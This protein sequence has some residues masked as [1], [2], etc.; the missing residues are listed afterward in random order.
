LTQQE[1]G[2]LVQGSAGIDL[3]LEAA[4][5]IHNRTDGNPF[6]VGEVTRH[7]TLENITEDPGWASIIPEGVRDAIGRRLNRLSDHCNQML[8]T[9]SV[10]GQEFEFRLLNSLMSDIT[11]D[12]LLAAMDEAVEV[13]LIEEL[14]NSVGLYQFTHPLIQETLFEELSTTRRVRLHARIAEGLET[15]YGNDADV[16]AEE[17]AYHFAEAQTLT[18]PEKLVRYSLMA[19]QQ[20]LASYAYD[21]ALTYFEKGLAARDIALS[22]TEAACDEEAADLLFGLARARS[23]TVEGQQLVEAFA[24][25][26][27]AFD[28]YAEAGN[29]A[30]AVAAALFPIVTPS[31]RIPGITGLLARALTLVPADSHEA[32]RILCVYGGFL[33]IDEGDY[34]GAQQAFRQA[35]SIARREGDVPLEVQTRT[36]VTVLSGQ[37]YHWQECVDN[38]VRA[39]ELATDQE[40]AIRASCWWTAIGFLH[41]GDLEAGRPHALFLGDLTEKR[42]TPR[43]YASNALTPITALSCLEGDWHAGREYSNQGLELSPLNPMLLLPRVLLEYETG[44]FA[45]GE[46]YLEQ[47]LEATGGAGPYQP[48]A[49]YRVPMTIATIARI[50]GIADRIEIAEA[51]AKAI[52]SERSATLNRAIYA[53]AGLALLAVEKGDQTASQEHYAALLSQR[54]TMIWTVVSV[55]RLLGL[56]SQTMGDLDQAATHFEEALTFSRKSGCRSE[57]A[58]TCCDYPDTLSLR[59]GSG[60]RAKSIALLDEALAI[61]TELGMRPLMDR[62]AARQ[63]LVQAQPSTAPAY[64]DGLTQREVE[65]L[66]LVAA[67]KSNAD[68]AEE[69]VISPNT[70]IRHVSNI[71]AKTGSSNRTEAAR[72]ASQNGLVE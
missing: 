31:Y 49:S 23:N 7:V 44:D 4:E 6:F 30:Q 71:L 39:I 8:T 40:N 68:I 18:G 22:G 55:D 32:G 35:I 72:Y 56:L 64:P 20:A 43:L 66:G 53:K 12:Q 24:I 29:V 34:E 15:L 5:A 37:Q 19:G 54:S 28:Y 16:H 46:V 51:T 45:Q 41:L 17:L 59:D 65:V 25:L 42:N 36:N 61:S 33:G 67:G 2:E 3:T 13:Q 14:P 50:T 27:R 70:V 47:L 38:G 1:V 58:W 60:D 62:V 11:E 48:L 52:V 9:A 21:D 26:S 10:V 57:L 63:E 69:L